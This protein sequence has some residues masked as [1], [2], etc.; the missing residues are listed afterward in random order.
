M[1]VDLDEI[2]RLAKAATTGEWKHRDKL[3][4]GTPHCDVIAIQPDDWCIVAGSDPSLWDMESADAAF[5]A[6]ANPAVV[7][8][9]IARLRAAEAIVSDLA[10]KEPRVLKYNGGNY[11]ACGLCGRSEGSGPF[12]EWIA[13]GMQGERPDGTIEHAEFCPWRRAIEY[14]P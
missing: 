8:E 2:Q 9:L 4:N 7:L 13:G 3:D 6:A 11:H 5:I 12:D 14:K 10:A 1:S